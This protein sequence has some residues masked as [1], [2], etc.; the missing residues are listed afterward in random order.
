M[1][2]SC[3]MILE[4]LSNSWQEIEI[5][6]EH[7]VSSLGE[8]KAP[9]SLGD[10]AQVLASGTPVENSKSRNANSFSHVGLF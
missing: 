5:A 6:A 8:N 1:S 2:L 9:I 3:C 10:S 4:I 7:L